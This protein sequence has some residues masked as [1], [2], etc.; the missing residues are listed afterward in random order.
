VARKIHPASLSVHPEAAIVPE[1]PADQ[2]GRFKADIKVR[3]ILKPIELIPGTKVVID[4]RTR[5][6]AAIELELPSVPV[7]DADMHGDSPVVYMLRTAFLRRQLTAGQAAALAVELESQLAVEA[8]ERQREGGRAAGRGRPKKGTTGDAPA[9]PSGADLST[10]ANFP[11]AALEHLAYRHHISTVDEIDS[12]VQLLRV[13][14]QTM[15]GLRP[16][17]P[18]A[19]RYTAL[20]AL[21]PGVMAKQGQKEVRAA[22]L[23]GDALVDW[24]TEQASKLADE[25]G[26]WQRGQKGVK[27]RDLAAA[28]A[29]SNPHYVSDAKRLKK[30]SPETFEKLKAGE[31]TLPEAKR[32]VTPKPATPAAS[33]AKDK[34]D[35]VRHVAR[36]GHPPLDP[37]PFCGSAEVKIVF[38]FGVVSNKTPMEYGQCEK[39]CACGPRKP[40]SMQARSA[41]NERHANEGKR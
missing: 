41:W 15:L 40:G 20:R 30:E 3:G 12:L 26:E 32:I 7:V 1:M 28:I 19:S 33:K 39:C 14:S 22:D 18:S 11:P 6:K 16:P 29:G 31:I 37:C 5:L 25:T 10:I 35:E 24:E 9:K 27:S 34:T 38:G 23:A 17:D 36:G 2:Y 8:K 13:G 4:G 21:L